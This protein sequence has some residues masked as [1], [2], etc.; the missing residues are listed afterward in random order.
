M[1]INLSFLPFFDSCRDRNSMEGPLYVLGTQDLH[2]PPATI[3][4]FARRSGY[5]NL[6]EKHSVQNLFLDRY[7]IED[8]K[9]CDLNARTDVV[10]DLNKPIEDNLRNRAGTVLDAGTVEHVLNVAQCLTTIHDLTRPGGTIIH[11][12]PVTWLNHAFYNFNPV[13]FKRIAKV[14][15]YDIMIEAYHF[16]MNPFSFWKR[17][18]AKLFVTFNGGEQVETG[19]AVSRVFSLTRI[20]VGILYMIAYRKLTE[21]DFRYPYDVQD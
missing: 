1:G 2:D 11:I 16:P 10:L 17:R 14:N 18:E 7:G 13:L 6:L 20:P 19:A 3:D 9:T 5:A 12:S 8:Y 21:N 4:A 15:D